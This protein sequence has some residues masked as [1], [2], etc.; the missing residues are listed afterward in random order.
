LIRLKDGFVVDTNLDFGALTKRYRELF[1]HVDSSVTPSLLLSIMGDARVDIHLASEYNSEIVTMP[2]SANVMQIKLS[3]IIK[4]SRTQ[5][6]E[7]EHFQDVTL[8]NGRALREAINSGSKSFDDFMKL[9][10]KS[11]KF[12]SWVSDIN[13]DAGLLRSYVEEVSSESWL[14]G[15]PRKIFRWIIFTGLGF[16]ADQYV[17]PLGSATAAGIDSFLVDRLAGG[18]KPS[19]FVQ[20]PL[21][22]FVTK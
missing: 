17:P 2:S 22:S 12:R 20:G 1:P 14:E 13:P 16:A 3:E 5:H 11:K 8:H 9:L 19:Q 18:W 7:I 4:R 10:E 21:T 15:M 6:E